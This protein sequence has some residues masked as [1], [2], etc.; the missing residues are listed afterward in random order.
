M[1]CSV[2]PGSPQAPHMV[3]VA[4]APHGEACGRGS[5]GVSRSQGRNDPAVSGEAQVHRGARPAPPTKSPMEGNSTDPAPP[6]SSHGLNPAQAEPDA[7][8]MDATKVELCRSA[9]TSTGAGSEDRSQNPGA[10]RGILGRRSA[11]RRSGAGRSSIGQRC[12]YQQVHRH[13]RGRERSAL[14]RPGARQ[15]RRNALKRSASRR[16]SLKQRSGSERVHRYRGEHEC[17]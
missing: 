17:R 8:M 11:P 10:R 4:H 14:R 16:S 9:C 15:C 7:E 6:L 13:G 12:G 2:G 1:G 5:G 3:R